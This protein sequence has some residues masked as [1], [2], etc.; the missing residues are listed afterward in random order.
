MKVF[1]IIIM[2]LDLQWTDLGFII[3]FPFDVPVIQVDTNIILFFSTFRSNKDRMILVLANWKAPMI[4][5][6]VKMTWT[7]SIRLQFNF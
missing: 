5:K 4:I 6:F 1:F 2:H 3:K 7:L